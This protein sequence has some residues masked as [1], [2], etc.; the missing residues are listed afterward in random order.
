MPLETSDAYSALTKVYPRYGQRHPLSCWQDPASYRA[1]FYVLEV[2]W[3]TA[4]GILHYEL[5]GG[6]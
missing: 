2:R 3:Q 1:G 4:L 5:E 6:F